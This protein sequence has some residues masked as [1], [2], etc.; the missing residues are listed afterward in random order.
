MCGVWPLFGVLLPF[1]GDVLPLDG[2]VLLLDD[3]VRLWVVMFCS[4]C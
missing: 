2:V 1:V 4:G 3:D